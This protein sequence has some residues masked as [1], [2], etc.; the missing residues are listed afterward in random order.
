MSGDGAG[1]VWFDGAQKVV[2]LH[3]HVE[4]LTFP[5]HTN[6]LRHAGLPQELGSA[7]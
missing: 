2:L 5:V 3:G 4:E 7:K 6:V 1:C